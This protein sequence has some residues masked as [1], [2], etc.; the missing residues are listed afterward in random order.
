L[1]RVSRYRRS[2]RSAASRRAERSGWRRHSAGRLQGQWSFVIGMPS[3]MSVPQYR[4][5]RIAVSMGKA[6]PR[7]GG[8]RDGVSES[9]TGD[10]DYSWHH[11]GRA[12]RFWHRLLSV[13][14]RLTGSTALHCWPLRLDSHQFPGQSPAQLRRIYRG[15]LS[16]LGLSIPTVWNRRSGVR[17]LHRNY[18]RHALRCGATRRRMEYEQRST[19]S[20][21]ANESNRRC[22][23]ARV[24]RG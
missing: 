16:I 8:V 1:L 12:T 22:A 2:W 6:N 11:T 18:R 24:R 23:H 7:H 3:T 15:R 19:V 5:S 4:H 20:H 14:S 21:P 17:T 9:G 13:R 10:P